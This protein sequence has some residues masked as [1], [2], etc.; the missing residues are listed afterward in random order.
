M[1][2]GE[3]LRRLRR[4]KGWSQLELATKARIKTSHISTMETSD[5]GDPKLSTIYKLLNA[6][7]CSPNTLLQDENQVGT[8]GI[9]EATLERA[10]GLDEQSKRVVAEIIDHYCIA[11]GLQ[12][13]LRKDK[14]GIL[15]NVMW[16]TADIEPA[17][18]KV[19]ED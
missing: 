13:M 17:I 2:F 14:N 9:L 19:W 10:S 3:N 1:S 15:P 5:A 4:D 8:Q 6:L 7:G 12:Q 16:A 11:K 18:K